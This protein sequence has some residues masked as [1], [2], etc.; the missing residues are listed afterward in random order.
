VNRWIAAIKTIFCRRTL[1]ALAVWLLAVPAF[2]HS[3]FGS[4]TRA[5]LATNR[6]EIY[7]T[8]G[9]Y[10]AAPHLK[11]FSPE[12]HR[13]AA[14]GLPYSLPSEIAARLYEVTGDR[15][16]LA[17]ERV[18][19]RLDGADFEFALIYPRPTGPILNL[20]A[21]YLETPDATGIVPLVLEDDNG[22]QLSS[23]LLSK[24]Q[25]T[26]T[27]A[28]S[29][30]DNAHAT[31]TNTSSTNPPTFREFLLL[32]IEHILTGFDH[33]LFLG[34]L[35]IGCRWLAPMLGVIT[36]FT[37]AHSITL[38]LAAMN[39]VVISSRVVEPLIAASIICVALENFRRSQSVQARC[40]MAF[41]FGL[42][43][44]FGF[45]SAL[46]ETGL[47][48]RGMALVKPLFSFNL[49]VE[50]GQLAVA[51]LFLPVLFWLDRFQT[52]QRYGKPTLSAAITLV[53]AY[54]LFER[55]GAYGYG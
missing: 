31:K 15:K 5:V 54:W 49:G 11:D 21:M 51:F 28:L 1:P 23:A 30:T 3:P 4:S 47:G 38:V 33:L 25:N 39:V 14:L 13:P 7:V 27:V 17:A 46:R 12:T 10:L 44:G 36:C 48:S 50:L 6:L 37:L 55:I 16:P 8:A 24:S 18:E 9:E 53:S 45:A 43:H 2:A 52:F 22:Q 42:I 41:G 29:A 40:W 20:R 26:M 35:L 34:A 32:G 19:L